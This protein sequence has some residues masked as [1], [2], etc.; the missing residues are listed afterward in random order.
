M[1][2]FSSYGPVNTEAHYYAPRKE[3]ITKAYTRLVGKDP[4]KSGHYFTVWAPRHSGK[5]W[6]M[7]QVLFKLKKETQ[8]DTVMIGLGVLNDEDESSKVIS[9][10][11]REIGE[12]LQ[13]DFSEINDK[14][15][16]SSWQELDNKYGKT[17]ILIIK[18]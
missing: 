17:N 5:S 14:I 15:F 2:R 11:T 6:L 9:I 4:E 1:R 10:I 3:I 13:K 12:K 18:S 16:G 8:F 7:N